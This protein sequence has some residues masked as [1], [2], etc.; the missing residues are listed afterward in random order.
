MVGLFEEKEREKKRPRGMELY[1]QLIGEGKWLT[2]EIVLSEDWMSPQECGILAAS[3]SRCGKC[4]S[5]RAQGPRWCF[6]ID[7][8]A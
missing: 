3:D 7:R 5:T 1:A 4:I 8:R 2:E 6:R